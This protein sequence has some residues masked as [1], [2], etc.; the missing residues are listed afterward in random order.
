MLGWRSVVQ[1][2]ASAELIGRRRLTTRGG[3]RVT[4]VRGDCDQQTIKLQKSR[5]T[6]RQEARN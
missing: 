6:H 4:S 2:R 1:Q 3:I 5:N